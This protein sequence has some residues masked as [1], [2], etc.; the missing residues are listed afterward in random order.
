[1]SR[2]AEYFFPIRL[3]LSCE[4]DLIAFFISISCINIYL[5]FLNILNSSELF[6]DANNVLTSSLNFTLLWRHIDILTWRTVPRP[7]ADFSCP[8]PVVSHWYTWNGR[9]VLIWF[10]DFPI[11]FLGKKGSGVGCLLCFLLLKLLFDWKL[12]CKKLSGKPNCRSVTDLTINILGR[13]FSKC[14]I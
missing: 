6:Y 10:F 14:E 8:A 9:E 13:V 11:L 4:K 12:I 3:L 7:I 1:M 2:I 5:N